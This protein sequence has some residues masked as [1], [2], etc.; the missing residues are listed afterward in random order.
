MQKLKDKLDVFLGKT[1][2]VKCVSYYR[3]SVSVNKKVHQ[4]FCTG[5]S[6]RPGW[7]KNSRPSS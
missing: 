6:A 4:H 2:K 3:H 5:I 7:E 1:L